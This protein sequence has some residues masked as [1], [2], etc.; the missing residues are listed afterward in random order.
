MPM[1][2]LRLGQGGG[3]HGIRELLTDASYTRDQMGA[4]MKGQWAKGQDLLETLGNSLLL[5]ISVSPSYVK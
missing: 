3:R 5:C 4:G 1:A 2:S